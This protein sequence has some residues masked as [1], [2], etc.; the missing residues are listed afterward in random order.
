M[1]LEPSIGFY[2]RGLRISSPQP[3]LHDV[4]KSLLGKAKIHILK[5]ITC[6]S[7]KRRPISFI[8]FI[9]HESIICVPSPLSSC[10]HMI[11]F[12]PHLVTGCTLVIYQYL[13][14]SMVYFIKLK[15]SFRARLQETI[16]K[17]PLGN[18]AYLKYS[19]IFPSQTSL[20]TKQ[21]TF[22]FRFF[23]FSI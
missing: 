9:S 16:T 18:T 7:Q 13:K 11:F 10:Y 19:Q 20:N 14:F 21:N 17:I 5:L 22:Q 12:K 3:L 8:S 1:W 6:P 23:N 4:Y 15:S 2:S